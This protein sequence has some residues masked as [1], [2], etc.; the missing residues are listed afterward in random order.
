MADRDAVVIS[1]DRAWSSA[2]ERDDM[3]VP[4]ATDQLAFQVDEYIH[5][6][7]AGLEYL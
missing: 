5:Q 3:G 4:L 7:G 6:L 2:D 1:P